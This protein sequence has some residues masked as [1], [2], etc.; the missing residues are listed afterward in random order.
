MFLLVQ[1]SAFD[2][3]LLQS[4][5]LLVSP[6]RTW[7]PIEANQG[8]I[9]NFGRIRESY[10][11]VLSPYLL[12]EDNVYVDCRNSL[13]F[14]NLNEK[15]APIDIHVKMRRMLFDGRGGIKLLIGMVLD[16][17]KGIPFAKLE[18]ALEYALNLKIRISAPTQKEKEVKLLNLSAPFKNLYAHSSSLAQGDLAQTNLV[19]EQSPLLLLDMS[20]R[21]FEHF[22]AGESFPSFSFQNGIRMLFNPFRMASKT[23]RG[24]LTLNVD[25][26][27]LNRLTKYHLSQL[28]AHVENMKSMMH[29]HAYGEQFSPRAKSSY[30][31]AHS[32]VFGEKLP[33]HWREI[34]GM[35]SSLF[36]KQLERLKNE[37]YQALFIPI[38]PN[39]SEI[40]LKLKTSLVKDGLANT[41]SLVHE[42]RE[43]FDEEEQE[44]LRMLETRYNRTLR[45]E[46]DGVASLE[47][48]WIERN[49]I[50][51]ALFKLFGGV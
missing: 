9:N 40:R 8:F 14:S 44:G 4:P 12:P 46:R 49:R 30:S 17:G 42:N 29:F 34:H 43:I 27:E 3:R 26:T 37:N 15:E 23:L 20:Q 1:F 31:H 38:Q 6:I 35:Y 28:H 24:F 32:I 47:E 13:K 11:S 21:E 19:R 33:D 18:E 5:D 41:F 16:F 39:Q 50:S 2:F 48:L 45:D 22:R 25:S 10:K 36:P 7:P 51:S